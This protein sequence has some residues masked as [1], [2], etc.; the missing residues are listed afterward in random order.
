MG[1]ASLQ[2]CLVMEPVETEMCSVERCAKEMMETGG[3][4]MDSAYT[5]QKHV[6]EHVR[7][8][9]PSVVT[10]PGALLQ[11]TGHLKSAMESALHS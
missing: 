5:K 11:M 8:E 9:P 3:L 6:M 7:W 1:S 4:A 10:V 2:V